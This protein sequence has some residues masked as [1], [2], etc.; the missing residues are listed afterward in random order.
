MVKKILDAHVHISDWSLPIEKFDE[1]MK[2]FGIEKAIVMPDPI[3]PVI[4]QNAKKKG[5]DASTGGVR[6]KMTSDGYGF[7]AERANEHQIVGGDLPHD[8][9]F[10]INENLIRNCENYSNVYPYVLLPENAVLAKKILNEL[11]EKYYGKFFGLKFHPNAYGYPLHK[12]SFRRN[13]NDSLINYPVIIHTGI[14]RFDNPKNALKFAKQYAGNVCLAHCARFDFETLQQ[15]A[16]LKNVYIDISPSYY[17]NT[18]SQGT[19]LKVYNREELKGKTPTQLLLELVDIIGEDKV[20][21]G[22]DAP[23]GGVEEYRKLSETLEISPE[24]SNKIFRDNIEKFNSKSY[25]KELSNEQLEKEHNNL[26]K[27][28]NDF[29]WEEMPKLEI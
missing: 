13:I 12:V 5:G 6:I 10:K 2:Q 9:W 16:K 14:T 3:D 26:T 8:Y 19:N 28:R 1:Q 22:S 21:A 29:V 17:L 18:V 7:F 4:F 27:R 20:L 11:E 24:L 25:L 23:F 15:I